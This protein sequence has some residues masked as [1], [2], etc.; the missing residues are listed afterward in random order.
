MRVKGITPS[1]IQ[2]PETSKIFAIISGVMGRRPIPELN[3]GDLAEM[4]YAA[5]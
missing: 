1:T 5:D 2:I 4:V 3:S